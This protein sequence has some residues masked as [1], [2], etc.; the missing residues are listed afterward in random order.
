MTSMSRQSWRAVVEAGYAVPDDQPLGNLTAELVEML[1]DLDPELRDEIAL[2]VLATWIE[3]GH[4]DDLLITLG[5]S[6]ARGLMVGLGDDGTPTVFRRTFAALVV[7]ACIDRDTAAHLV[8]RDV[9]LRWSDLGI[10]WYLAE[11]DLRGQVPGQGRAHAGAHGA[12]LLRSVA[13]S[14]HAGRDE[15][16]VVLDVIGE[17]LRTPTKYT[18]VDG[19]EDRLALAALTVVYRG[20]VAGDALDEWVARLGAGL[21]APRDDPAWPTPAVHNLSAFIRAMYVH[22]AAGISPPSPGGTHPTV[23][24]RPPSG[25]PDLL[26]ALLATIPGTAPRLYSARS[27]G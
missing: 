8:P 14:H 18:F 24:D 19:E 16:Q 26:L 25:R 2:S 10:G 22:L 1:G 27:P 5:D 3:R 23:F 12:D 20:L 9:F 13:G 11:R 4:Y 6:V 17:R 7:A 15:G 21:D